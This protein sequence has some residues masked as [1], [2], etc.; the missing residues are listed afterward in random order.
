MA[1]GFAFAR[2]LFPLP[3]P[4]DGRLEAVG[5]SD[6]PALFADDVVVRVELERAVE[7]I[8]RF[9][10]LSAR[11]ELAGEAELGV[12]ELLLE[13]LE[14]T[15]GLHAQLRKNVEVAGEESL[16]TDAR[17]FVA[18]A[19]VARLEVAD[20][21]LFVDED[22]GRDVRR[23]GRDREEVGRGVLLMPVLPHGQL[24]AAASPGGPDEKDVPAPVVTGELDRAPV[25]SEEDDI[26]ERPVWLHGHAPLRGNRSPKMLGPSSI[27]S[28]SGIARPLMSGLATR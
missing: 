6:R 8:E 21:P 11:E 7:R 23:V 13:R 10:L 12:D 26:G 25:E 27:A 20:D 18:G 24:L 15:A 17:V 9:L 1:F 3:L 14:A 22:A 28:G 19:E 2:E 4:V 5:V 16:D